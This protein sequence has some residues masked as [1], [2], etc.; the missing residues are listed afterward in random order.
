ME[1][2]RPSAAH[3]ALPAELG[4]GADGPH[5]RLFPIRGCRWRVARCSPRA[6]LRH[7]VASFTARRRRYDLAW[8]GATCSRTVGASL[9]T[10]RYQA[11]GKAQ[12]CEWHMV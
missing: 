12:H 11:H 1:W 6:L 3:R 10:A 4:S 8:C 5:D 7:E 9:A 2:E